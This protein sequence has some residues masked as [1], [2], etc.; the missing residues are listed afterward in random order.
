MSQS[1]ILQAYAQDG[2][3]FKPFG[4]MHQKLKVPVVG[5]WWVCLF[6]SLISFFLNLEQLTKLVSLGNLMTYAFVDAGVIALRLRPCQL[7]TPMTP[8]I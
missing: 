1:R 7:D 5:Q 4:R 3:F 2:L 6:A 8:G